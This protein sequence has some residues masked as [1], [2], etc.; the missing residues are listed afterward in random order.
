MFQLE[1]LKK[2]AKCVETFYGGRG[3]ARKPC[4]G[5][6]GRSAAKVS[7]RDI[8]HAQSALVAKHVGQAL[9]N[10]NALWVRIYKDQYGIDAS[11][12]SRIACGRGALISSTECGS[13]LS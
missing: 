8:S 5:W 1:C 3:Q 11:W 9:L 2:S 12:S 10:P 13:M 6:H 4:I 7:R